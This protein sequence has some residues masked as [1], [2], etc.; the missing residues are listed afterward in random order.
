MMSLGIFNALGWEKIIPTAKFKIQRMYG[1]W[2]YQGLDKVHFEGI[3]ED[4][5]NICVRNGLTDK[6]KDSLIWRC[7]N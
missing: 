5:I 2:F 7:P 3:I 1:S 6:T 4:A